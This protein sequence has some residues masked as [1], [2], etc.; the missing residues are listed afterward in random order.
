MNTLSAWIA[1]FSDLVSFFSF[2]LGFFLFSIAIVSLF[3]GS[4]LNVVIYRLPRIMQ[5]AWQEE[6]RVYLGLKPHT[7]PDHLSLSF[8]FS[9]CPQCKK[10]LKPWHNVPLLS[11]L[12][13]HGKCAFC[14]TSI[15]MRYP[16]VELL[17]A[18]ASVYVAWYY[19][20]STQTLAALFLTWS[21]IALT[22]IDIDH[23][24][25]PDQL[26][27]LILWVG[28]FVSLFNVFC[29]PQDAILGAIAGYIIFAVIEC[30]FKLVTGKIGMGQGDF[31]L[32]AGLG[33]FLGWQQ[34]P[35]IILLA[36][37]I[38]AVFGITHMTIKKQFKSVPLPFGPYLALAG[39]ICLLWGNEILATYW[40]WIQ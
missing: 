21:L 8:P 3:I 19:G 29:T 36:S 20:V 35:I 15:S 24:L 38:G 11:Y 14:R 22:F 31:K 13:M 5:N 23:Y 18:V 30:L 6:C 2:H 26:T 4:F 27:L 33:A 7:D 32:L 17:T 9:H 1:S 37:C 12:F 10:T 25:L 39:W 28:L 40:Q 34:L 16:I